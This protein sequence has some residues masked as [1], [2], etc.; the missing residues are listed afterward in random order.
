ML[1][2]KKKSGK[3]ALETNSLWKQILGQKR[4]KIMLPQ[5]KG[6]QDRKE[7]RLWIQKEMKIIKTDLWIHRE[8]LFYLTL[9][10]LSFHSSVGSKIREKKKLNE[11]QKGKEE[12]KKLKKKNK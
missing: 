7:K 12:K 4:R 6:W 8:Y 10:C 11:E 5:K 2:K 9:I 3:W 1:H